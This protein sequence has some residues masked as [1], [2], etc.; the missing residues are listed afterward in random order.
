MKLLEKYGDG[1]CITSIQSKS[2]VICF[3]RMGDKILTQHWYENRSLS[4]EDERLRVVRAAAQIVL[5][6]IRSQAYD[7][8]EYPSSSYFLQNLERELPESLNIFLGGN[9]LT[10]LRTFGVQFCVHLR[11]KF[12]TGASNC[13]Y[14]TYLSHL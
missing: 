3:R 14:I 8:S 1:V 2:P 7:M 4:E 11:V 10:Y 13:T 12:S 9:A 6:D 5:E